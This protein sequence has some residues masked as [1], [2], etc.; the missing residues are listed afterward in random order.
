MVGRLEDLRN[1]SRIIFFFTHFAIFHT[2]EESILDLLNLKIL[3]K[4]K[5]KARGFCDIFCQNL[6]NYATKLKSM[7]KSSKI[8]EKAKFLK[9]LPLEKV[10]VFLEEFILESELEY[11]PNFKKITL[12][13]IIFF[14]YFWNED[15]K[16]FNHLI[17]SLLK[18]LTIDELSKDSNK[19]FVG[20]MLKMSLKPKRFGLFE[21]LLRFFFSSKFEVT[22]KV[23][24]FFFDA[25]AKELQAMNRIE[26]NSAKEEELRM[27][28]IFICDLITRF[29]HQLEMTDFYRP[30]FSIKRFIK[31]EEVF[32]KEVIYETFIDNYLSFII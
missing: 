26:N 27:K 19:D 20:K 24:Q 30:D 14:S 22:P 12:N 2:S 7:E 13:R 16:F 10:N 3:L 18:K 6:E 29:T 28:F 11:Y 15:S 21:I 5:E 32:T 23:F 8:E 31:I 4:N 1:S 25:I 17:E 9:F